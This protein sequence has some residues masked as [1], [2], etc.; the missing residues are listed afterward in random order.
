MMVGYPLLCFPSLASL[1][2]FH[3]AK[4]RDGFDAKSDCR[5]FPP[6][7]IAVRPPFVAPMGFTKKSLFSMTSM[8]NDG[9]RS[10][11]STAAAAAWPPHC[12][13]H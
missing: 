6:P 5:L 10:V 13:V 9:P 7:S 12:I 8:V 2:P 3:S 1:F 4:G 11:P